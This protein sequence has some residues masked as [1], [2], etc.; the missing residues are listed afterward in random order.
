MKNG[1]VSEKLQ[2]QERELNTPKIP[3]ADEITSNKI[4]QNQN[5]S[6][7]TF[8]YANVPTFDQP[9]SHSINQSGLASLFSIL[10][11]K[12]KRLNIYLIFRRLDIF[13]LPR[14][15]NSIIFRPYLNLSL[16]TAKYGV[17]KNQQ[18][19]KSKEK[20]SKSKFICHTICHTLKIDLS[21][22]CSINRQCYGIIKILF[23]ES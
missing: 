18:V 20:V 6:V 5:S 3:L 14:Q 16:H 15:D 11:P 17:F 7:G 13:L 2:M 21:L 9:T 10:A 23:G 12:E 19:R 22:F 1:T 8:E 4:S